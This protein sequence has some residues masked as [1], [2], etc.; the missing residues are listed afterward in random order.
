MLG[1]RNP[2]QMIELSMTEGMCLWTCCRV[3]NCWCCWLLCT[4][5]QV[6]NVDAIVRAVVC[7]LQEIGGKIFKEM[8][9]N[10]KAPNSDFWRQK[11]FLYQGY[12]TYPESEANCRCQRSTHH[13]PHPDPSPQA[14]SYHSLDMVYQDRHLQKYDLDIKFDQNERRLTLLKPERRSDCK[15]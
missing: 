2:T 14:L 5:V 12:G 6:G 1:V 15:G 4:V 8:S 7:L 11:S 9:F 3:R 13:H 10:I